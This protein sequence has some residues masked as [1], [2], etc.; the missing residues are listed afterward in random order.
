MGGRGRGGGAQTIKDLLQQPRDSS[1]NTKSLRNS[2]PEEVSNADILEALRQGFSDLPS[3]IAEEVKSQ[4][5]ELKPSIA[6]MVE[7]EVDKHIN[8]LSSD[9]ASIKRQLQLFESKEESRQRIEKRKNIVIHNLKI[10]TEDRVHEVEQF[11]TD[12]FDLNINVKEVAPVKTAGHRNLV[13]VKLKS[14]D[15]KKKVMQERSK[16]TDSESYI[17][18]DRTKKE[19]EI[20][21]KVMALAAEEK[22]KGKEVKVGHMKM[23][24]D[25]ET[26]VWRE[27]AGLVPRSGKFSP[28]PRRQSASRKNSSF[29]GAHSETH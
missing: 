26:K 18:A 6:K 13:V 8:Q 24:V 14:L 1:K 4:L 23:T 7:E 11:L 19:R 9:L 22:K 25:G 10:N 29:R 20:Q 27:G 21:K 12:N 16:L 3:V 2:K 17:T 5:A 15:D 28:S